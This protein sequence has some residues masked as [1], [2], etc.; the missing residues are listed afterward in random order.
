MKKSLLLIILTISV[1]IS[2]FATELYPSIM[3]YQADRTALNRKYNNPLSEEYFQ[4]FEKLY[5]EWLKAL[6][7]MPYETY[8]L[9]G[10]MDWQL[11]KNHLEKELFFH[12]LAYEDFKKINHVADFKNDL[13]KFYKSRRM[14]VKPNAQELAATFS[15]I[16][17]DIKTKWESMKKSKPFDAWQKA[18]LASQT[19][20][21]LRKSTEE[22]YNFYYDYDP[23]F[24]W[25]M[26]EPMKS[27]DKSMKDYAAFL[28]SHFENT[29]VKDDGSGI[30]GKP[31]GKLA[32]E[33]ELAYNM[34]P[35]TAEELLKEGE[36]QYAWCEAEMIKASNELGFG[37]DWKAAL[38]HVKNTY[39]PAGEWPQIVAEMAEEAIAFLEDNDLI[40]V[41]EMAKET[42]R[43]T[44]MS[45][46]RQRVNPFFLGGESI[47][48][49]YPTSTMTQEEKMMSMRGNNPHFSRATVQHELIPGHHLQQFMNQRHFPHRRIF[50]TPF[51][52]E[53]WTLYWEF[54][55]WDK[56]F[57]RN[58]E[59]RI[60]ML[61][62]RMHRAARIVFSLNYHLGNMTPQ[63]CID[64]LVDKV[65]HERAN[66]EAEVRRS[67]EGS[68]GPLYQLA[69]MIGGLQVYSLKN[70]MVQ[71]GKMTEKQFHD[72]F[73]SQN[74]MPIELLR[75]RMKGEDLPRNFKSS[76]RFL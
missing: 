49:S 12:G 17:K 40:T 50:N 71:S 41:P 48:I 38:E 59:D 60:G 61:F 69:Y 3:S 30:I 62:W 26:K 29:V 51:W 24:T 14:A 43:T 2:S 45:A 66:A 8:S 32:I 7:N 73:I 46:E 10:K 65:G 68:Y 47:I 39:V 28:K 63:E 23:E 72:F 34:I 75:A 42:W 76:W 13:E 19:V 56:G 37:N 70:E 18:E 74:Y 11:F 35:Y 5:Q 31:V 6:E 33:T 9:D 16:E 52:V 21:A 44:M 22:A 15:K 57:P 25:W 1:C 4:R 64:F 67:F 53:G 36:K 55:L 27:L 54:N 58:A 20:E